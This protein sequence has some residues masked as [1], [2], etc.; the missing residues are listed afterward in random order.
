MWNGK[1]NA[2]PRKEYKSIEFIEFQRLLNLFGSYAKKEFRQIREFNY[3]N[4][5]IFRLEDSDIGIGFGLIADSLT[6]VSTICWQFGP[7]SEW[8]YAQDDQLDLLKN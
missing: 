1:Y 3:A 2:L 6:G 5:H 8:E 7:D 4:C